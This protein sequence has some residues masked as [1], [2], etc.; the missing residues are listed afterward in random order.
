M[1][2][3]DGGGKIAMVGGSSDGQQR[4]NGR[5]DGE[6][7]V[8]GNRMVVAQW[9]AHGWQIIAAKAEAVQWEA[10]QNGWQRQS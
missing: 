1:I 6:V 3:M 5:R 10:M 9:T 2:M 8:M 4:R 7:I